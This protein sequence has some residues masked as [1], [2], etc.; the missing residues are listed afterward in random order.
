MR[1][2]VALD[3][4][5]TVYDLHTPWLAYLRDELGEDVSPGFTTWDVHRQYP[6][7][8]PRVYD[9]L[10]REGLFLGL[11]PLPYAVEAI[12]AVASRLNVRQVF[13]TTCTTKSGAW[14]K[15]QAVARDFPALASEVI[16][17]SGAKDI[18]AA[19]LLVDD[20]PLNLEAF[21]GLTCRVPYAYNAHV[22]STF[23]LSDWSAYPALIESVAS[24]LEAA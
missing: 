23:T 7:S 19:Q 14:E 13:L 24:M 16:V 17:T 21:P 20:G 9:I 4:D 1:F 15:Q 8:G 22:P 12:H 6:R 3:L 11:K 5:A 2:T 18:I 10:S